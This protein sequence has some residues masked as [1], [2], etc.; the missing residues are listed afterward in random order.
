MDKSYNTLDRHFH[1]PHVRQVEAS[2][3]LVWLRMGWD[4]MLANPG[5]SLSYG[6]IF[7]VLGYLIL[8]YATDMPYL[9]TAAVSG[10]FLV[11]PLA[12]AG[13]YELSRRHERGE[14][15]GLIDSLKGLRQHGDHL[16]YYGAFL[17]FVL[18]GWE[19]L[20]AILFALFYHGDTPDLAHFFRDVFLSGNYV[21]FVVSY[22]V[23][24]GAL[25][26]LVFALSVVS[27]P[28]LMDR[29]SDMVTAMMT[30]ARAVGFNLGAMAVWAALIVALIGLGFATMMIGMVLLLPL[31][32]HATWHAYKDLVE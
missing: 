20:S 4:D 6:L 1:L 24:G 12:A 30:S 15:A 14:A 18:L 26:G 27:V 25:A 7:A 23:V 28:M 9:F 19:R 16:L 13:L 11:G 17:A 32:G 8:A 29:S 2:R 3:P 10:F 5:A 22:L 21:H 31:V